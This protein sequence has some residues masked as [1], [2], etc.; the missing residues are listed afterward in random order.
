M[1]SR[2]STTSSLVIKILNN[3]FAPIVNPIMMKAFLLL[4]IRQYTVPMLYYHYQ[5]RLYSVVYTVYWQRFQIEDKAR[6]ILYMLSSFQSLLG[7]FPVNKKGFRRKLSVLVK[8]KSKL[9]YSTIYLAYYIGIN[10][11]WPTVLLLLAIACRC[12]NNFGDNKLDDNFDL[13]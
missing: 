4:I 11:I 2:I 7:P 10:L 6:N 9:S 3:R 13:V 1:G 5:Y 12:C 8:Q